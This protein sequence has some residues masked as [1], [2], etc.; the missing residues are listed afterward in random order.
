MYCNSMLRTMSGGFVKSLVLVRIWSQI[1]KPMSMP[2]CFVQWY[3]FVILIIIFSNDISKYILR[4]FFPFQGQVSSSG[5]FLWATIIKKKIKSPEASY[6][7]SYLYFNY[8]NS[9]MT[10]LNDK[11]L[12]ESLVSF[13]MVYISTWGLFHNFRKFQSGTEI[14]KQMNKWS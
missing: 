13:D 3:S 7:C 14:I 12:L 1:C 10:F 9:F 11:M 6:I 4:L 2:D 8:L 5:T